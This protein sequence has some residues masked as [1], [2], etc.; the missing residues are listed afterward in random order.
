VSLLC[1]RLGAKG[2][3]KRVLVTLSNGEREYVYKNTQIEEIDRVLSWS[4][5]EWGR[6]T[7]V[8]R[9]TE[10]RIC[11]HIGNMGDYRGDEKLLRNAVASLQ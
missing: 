4:T 8:Y 7:C 10:G 11:S 3:K 2:T 9:T 1:C 6:T 5:D